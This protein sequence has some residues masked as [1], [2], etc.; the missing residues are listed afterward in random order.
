[1][2][3]ARYAAGDYAAAFER[4]IAACAA[5]GEWRAR[6]V[7]ALCLAQP[8]GLTETFIGQADGVIA[9]VPEGVGGFGYDPVFV[10]DGY[11]RSYA[12]L[13]GAVKDGI[14]HRARAVA[15]LV[16]VLGAGRE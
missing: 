6:F 11:E 14:S 3:S 5:A 4:I 7:C 10:P 8:N 12:V 13:G 16:A 9:R 1:V 15:Q 2:F